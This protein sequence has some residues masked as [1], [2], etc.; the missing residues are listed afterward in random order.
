MRLAFVTEYD[1]TN[2]SGFQKQKNA[3][4]VQEVI[5]DALKEITKE[6]IS[7]NYAGR[8]D[9][10]VHALSQ[11]FDFTTDIKRD[12][13]NWI[14]GMNSNLPDSISI[15]SISDV[16]NDFHSRFSALDRSYTYVVYNS[17]TKP[18][19]FDNLVHWDD[20]LI[21]FSSI[22]EQANMFLGSHDFTSFRSSR[23]SSNNPV[24]DIKSIEATKVNNFIFITI[25]ANAFLHN[26]V[27]IISGT[28]IDIAK[29]EIN[30]SI[31][32]ILLKKNRAAAG[33]TASAKGL[34]FLG[35]QYDSQFQIQSPTINIMDKF[36][37]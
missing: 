1:G 6:D 18:L 3:I 28:L 10:G 20:N 9:A 31:D 35:P 25:K 5:E 32:E 11:V 12:H 36:K 22:Q 13:K 33:K 34:F 37:S 30:L 29:G 19:F 4:S 15:K 14:D 23:C 21:E 17:K 8:T 26:M 27:R 7:I 2:F 16:P 24:K